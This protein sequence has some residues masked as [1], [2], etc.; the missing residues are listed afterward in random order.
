M[1]QYLGFEILTAV[2]MKNSIFRDITPCN[3]LNN[4]LSK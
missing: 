1:F 3:Q 4:E 2:V